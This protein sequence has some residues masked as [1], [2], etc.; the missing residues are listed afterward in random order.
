MIIYQKG[1]T[2][3]MLIILNNKMT[4]VVTSLTFRHI[5]LMTERDLNDLLLFSDKIVLLIYRTNNL[6]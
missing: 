1:S 3:I 4:V 6:P 5:V 2:I